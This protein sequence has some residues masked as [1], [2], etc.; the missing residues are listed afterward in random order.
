MSKKDRVQKFARAFP[1]VELEPVK[2]TVI[3]A[4]GR[5]R[6]VVVR[7]VS[8]LVHLQILSSR[9][10]EAVASILRRAQKAALSAET[11]APRSEEPTKI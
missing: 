6:P 8:A 10:A 4:V 1:A 7:T 5:G 3:A 9:R 2:P 11:Q